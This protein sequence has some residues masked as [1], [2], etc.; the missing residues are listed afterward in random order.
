M[1]FELDFDNKGQAVSPLQLDR[2]ITE[3]KR[4]G[5][6]D[7]IF[8]AHGFRCA[9]ADATSLYTNLL[10]TLLPTRGQGF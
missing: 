5:A 8:L 4:V 2:L 3:S 10:A 6:T 9:P 7:L 1:I